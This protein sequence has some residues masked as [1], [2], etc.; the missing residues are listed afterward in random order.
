LVGLNL[1]EEGGS[2]RRKSGPMAGW[3]YQWEEGWKDGWA[4]AW[5]RKRNQWVVE[6]N[7]RK[8][9]HWEEGGTS[10]RKVGL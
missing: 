8:G 7:R 4:D 2:S 1:W 10:G 3:R 9:Y 6:T 5:G